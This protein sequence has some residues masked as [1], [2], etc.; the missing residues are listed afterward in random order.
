MSLSYVV[1]LKP[2]WHWVTARF[3]TPRDT[4]TLMFSIRTLP[5]ACCSVCHYYWPSCRTIKIPVCL[6]VSRGPFSWSPIPGLWESE[7]K[8]VHH[9]RQLFFFFFLLGFVRLRVWVMD[10]ATA[11]VSRG[12]A[13]TSFSQ[14]LLVHFESDQ[15]IYT[16]GP[17]HAESLMEWNQ[18]IY[19][20][21]RSSFAWG[22]KN[23]TKHFVMNMSGV[24]F[25]CM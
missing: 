18:H 8:N 17:C 5:E 25:V 14:C 11:S 3:V 4:F 20:C 24:M 9:L 22:K 12:T 10:A 6:K 13:T 15:S 19:K 16:K 23:K 7:V 2:Q 21:V 1:I